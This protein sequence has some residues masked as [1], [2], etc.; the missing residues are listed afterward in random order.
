MLEKTQKLLMSTA[1]SLARHK[2]TYEREKQQFKD[3]AG[4][5]SIQA[6][7]QSKTIDGLNDKVAAKQVGSSKP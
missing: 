3:A 2:A 5:A 1:S 4:R 6:E 7:A